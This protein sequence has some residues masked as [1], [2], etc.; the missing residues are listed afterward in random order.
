LC[1]HFIHLGVGVTKTLRSLHRHRGP[2]ITNVVNASATPGEHGPD[3]VLNRRQQAS[4]TLSGA[5]DAGCGD[6]PDYTCHI[7]E[8]HL[9]GTIGL[10]WKT[11]ARADIVR[12]SGPTTPGVRRHAPDQDL[13]GA[14]DRFVPAAAAILSTGLTTARRFRSTL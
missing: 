12:C 13:P 10:G 11:L 5:M 4:A 14:G 3:N 8:N 6:A 2:I 1:R 9:G 7:F